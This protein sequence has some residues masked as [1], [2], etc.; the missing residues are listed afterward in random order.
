VSGISHG[1]NDL[2]P[3]IDDQHYS[4][5]KGLQQN[6]QSL[7][8]YLRKLQTE[9]FE[10]TNKFVLKLHHHDEEARKGKE[11]EKELEKLREDF[12]EK[13]DRLRASRRDYR[14]LMWDAIQERDNYLASKEQ[15]FDE[16]LRA[17]K[18]YESITP[19][20]G[21]DWF[22]F[23]FFTIQLGICLL[24]L[25]F[26]DYQDLPSMSVTRGDIGTVDNYYTFLI[27]M[28]FLTFIG[29]GLFAGLMRNYRWSGIGFNLLAGA[30]AMEFTFI[31]NGL[32]RMADRQI[33]SEAW[34]QTFINIYD[35]GPTI[36]CAGATM[37][38]LSAISGN[39]SPV[40]VLLMTTFEVMAWVINWW[41]VIER[42]KVVDNGGSMTVHTFGAVFGLVFSSLLTSAYN[43][44][45][46]RKQHRRAVEKKK[47]GEKL[48]D[49]P[50]YDEYSE[51][52]QSYQTASLALGGIIFVCAFFPSWNAFFSIASLQASTVINTIIAIVSSIVT[53]AAASYFLNGQRFSV[54]D[55]QTA[56]ISGGV[57][58]A[59]AHSMFIP[60]WSASFMGLV[61]SVIILTL[62][63][64]SEHPALHSFVKTDHSHSFLRHGVP[65]ILAAVSSMIVI[66]AYTGQTVYGVSVNDVFSDHGTDQPLFQLYGLLISIGIAAIGA[67]VAALFLNTLNQQVKPP[68]RPFIETQYWLQLGTDYSGAAL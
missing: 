32:L 9:E 50:Q 7:Q 61:T 13:I 48:E 38:S 54:V 16:T 63:R 36:Y 41:F 57:V 4:Y 20:R 34:Q 49:V 25:L 33:D 58:L 2:I 43:A 55:L 60:A 62:L 11:N 40:G 59:S 3:Y 66:S 44:E 52:E 53:T 47:K 15:Q 1:S 27:D 31:L 65:G 10:V 45:R 17:R 6:I 39:L 35:V 67:F 68:R 23:L 14:A 26:L 29:F 37:I 64:L 28:L 51:N 24:Y 42:L 5:L 22:L 19:P 46:Q 30:Y 8:S 56:A 21:I 18:Q 12:Q